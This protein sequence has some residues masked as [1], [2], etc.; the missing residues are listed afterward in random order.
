MAISVQGHLLTT[1]ASATTSRWFP[2]NYLAN[3]FTATMGITQT[4][5]AVVGY[6]IDYT[7]DAS[8]ISGGFTPVVNGFIVTNAA[9][10]TS[11]PFQFPVVATRVRVSA[12]ASGV[13]TPPSLRIWLLQVGE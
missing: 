2:M 6:R 10:A 13:G 4:S 7:L 11:F 12:L 8:A 3:P 5:G 1:E 9:S